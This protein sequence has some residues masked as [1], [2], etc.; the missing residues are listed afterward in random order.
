MNKNYI[1][2]LIMAGVSFLIRALPM[3]LFRKQ[4]MMRQS[5]S[6]FAF[7]MCTM[8]LLP[9][10]LQPQRF[11]FVRLTGVILTGVSL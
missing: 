5:I 7:A 6:F 11:L 3:T 1:Y 10:T 8:C 9:Q 2:I 4:I